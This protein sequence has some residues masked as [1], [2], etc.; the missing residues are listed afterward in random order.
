MLCLCTA[1]KKSIYYGSVVQ[2]S[3][4]TC[5]I[6]TIGSIRGCRA[7]VQAG[8]RRPSAHIWPWTPWRSNHAKHPCPR[9]PVCYSECGF[10]RCAVSHQDIAFLCWD[11]SNPS[12][13]YTNANV[14]TVQ[15]S[16]QQKFKEAAVLLTEALHIRERTLGPVCSSSYYFIVL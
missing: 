4:A 15:C 13:A 9:V 14:N 11:I 2:Y 6:V 3:A 16:D 10:M 8:V 5:L 7:S 1:V 12:P